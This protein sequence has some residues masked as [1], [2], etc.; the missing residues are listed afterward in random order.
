[1]AVG[2]ALAAAVVAAAVAGP[3][4]LALAW[5]AAALLAVV[6]ASW[7]GTLI[8]SR[9]IVNPYEIVV[10][11]LFFRRRRPRSRAVEAVRAT[12]RGPRGSVND[13]VFLL[14]AHRAVLLRLRATTYTR[15]DIDRLVSALGVPCSGPGRAVSANEF[16]KQYPGLVSW[17]ER[18]PNLLSLV[19]AG[20]VCGATL[21]VALTSVALAS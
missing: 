9:I 14:D 6:I 1:M 8:R 16:A 15:S 4:P 13:N 11:G 3:A 2:V 20:A 10:R 19:I 21:A 17:V 12:I 18:H 7:T 5:G